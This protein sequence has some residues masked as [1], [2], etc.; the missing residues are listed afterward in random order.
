MTRQLIRRSRATHVA[1]A[2]DAPGATFRDTLFADY[3]AG[4]P[5]RPPAGRPRTTSAR[6]G[7]SS[8][9]VRR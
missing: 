9:G 3:K 5:G 8:D 4:R 7:G 1:F 2:F 6:Q